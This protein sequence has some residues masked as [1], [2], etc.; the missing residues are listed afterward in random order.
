MLARVFRT[1]AIFLPPTFLMFLDCTSQPREL[2]CTK[3][4]SI[5]LTLGNDMMMVLSGIVCHQ[6]LTIMRTNSNKVV[7]DV[8]HTSISIR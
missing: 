6:H 7:I 8:R 5:L 1:A 2:S 3:L 4:C